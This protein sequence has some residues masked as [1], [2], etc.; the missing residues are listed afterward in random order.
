MLGH[1]QQHHLLDIGLVTV[2]L[3]RTREGVG[4]LPAPTTRRDLQ[5]QHFSFFRLQ[6]Q[7]LAVDFLALG[8]FA[9]LDQSLDQ[10]VIGQGLALEEV[11]L[12]D[13]LDLDLVE[14]LAGDRVLEFLGHPG[15]DVSGI[16]VEGVFLAIS[17]KLDGGSQQLA[18]AGGVFFQGIDHP[19]DGV[20]SRQS[21]EVEGFLA[22][23]GLGLS[24]L[25]Q[26]DTGQEGR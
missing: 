14:G 11:Q 22:P 24:R 16:A 19:F 21:V 1:D 13:L 23:L 17:E 18:S 2:Q 20:V 5:R 4:N 26:P 3:I 15:Q 10:T 6:F 25:G 8:Q 9:V 7:E 12:T